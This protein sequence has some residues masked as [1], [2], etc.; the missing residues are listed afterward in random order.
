MDTAARCGYHGSVRDRGMFL[1]FEQR[2]P[3]FVSEALLEIEYREIPRGGA[4]RDPYASTTW[5][6]KPSD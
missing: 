1:G 4:A 2:Q 3:A 6:A 5:S